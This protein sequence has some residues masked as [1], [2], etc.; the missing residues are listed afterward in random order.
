MEKYQPTAVPKTHV[1]PTA[2]APLSNVGPNIGPMPTYVSPVSL[3]QPVYP[4]PINVHAS[5]EE[6]NIY[7]PKKTSPSSLAWTRLYFSGSHFGALHPAGH[8]SAQQAQALSLTLL[9]RRR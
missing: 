4:A 9:K 6:I 8:Y 7:T 2:Y 1:G 3:P 5:Y